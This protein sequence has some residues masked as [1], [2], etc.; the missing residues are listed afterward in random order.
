MVRGGDGVAVF[1]GR[2]HVVTNESIYDLLISA[3]ISLECNLYKVS[4]LLLATLTFSRVRQ[5][6]GLRL[7]ANQWEHR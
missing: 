7:A 3:L 4:L 2:E 5:Q 1:G 6:E